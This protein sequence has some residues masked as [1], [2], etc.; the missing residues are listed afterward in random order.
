MTA[1]YPTAQS[2]Q[3]HP[4]RYDNQRTAQIG[5]YRGQHSCPKLV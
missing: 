1:I 3:G 4:Q 5:I 2:D